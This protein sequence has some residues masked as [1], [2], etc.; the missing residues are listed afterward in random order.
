MAPWMMSALA[1]ILWSQV[2]CGFGL[3]RFA[4]VF[5]LS[6]LHLKRGF[7]ILPSIFWCLYWDHFFRSVSIFESRVVGL[8]AI[9]DCVSAAFTM[10]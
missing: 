8:G 4:C 10:Y 5:P 1:L 7:T 3:L 9:G 6:C 2:S